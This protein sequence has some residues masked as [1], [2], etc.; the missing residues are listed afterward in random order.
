MTSTARA[1]T[2]LFTEPEGAED[3][4]HAFGG[5]VVGDLAFGVDVVEVHDAGADLGAG[6]GDA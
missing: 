4:D 3:A 6:G 5:D 2:S 1:Y